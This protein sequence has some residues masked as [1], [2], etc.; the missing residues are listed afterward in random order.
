MKFGIFEEHLA[1]D[2]MIVKYYGLH[3]LKQFIRSKPIRF[4]YKFWALWGVSGYCYNFD[5]YCGKSSSDDNR[6]DLLLG[7]K[8][9]LNML[10]VVEEP[11]SYS[12]FFDNL[13]TGYELLVH[14]RELGSSNW[15]CAREQAKEMSFDGSKRTEKQK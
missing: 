6:A 1:V 8:V 13:F 15:N 5:L 3:A 10:D 14:L 7:S 9:V 2:E 11:Q 12:V 4:G